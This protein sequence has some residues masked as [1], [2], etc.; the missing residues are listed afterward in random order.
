MRLVLFFLLSPVFAWSQ[1]TAPSF[2]KGNFTDDYG[3]KYTINDTLWIQHPNIKY[4]II[5]WNEKKQYLIAKNGSGHKA[6]ESKYTRIDLIT[7]EGM[8]PWQ[9]GFCLT[10][11]KAKTDIEA[12]QTATADRKNPKKGCNGFPF[13]RMKVVNEQ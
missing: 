12:E 3:I 11:Y 2:A 5:K 8:A 10:S 7:F 1:N 4:H 6:D 9:W 13:S